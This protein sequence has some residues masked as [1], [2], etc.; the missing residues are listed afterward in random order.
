MP[1]TLDDTKLGTYTLLPADDPVLSA[2]EEL[3]GAFVDPEDPALSASFIE[4][5]S[6]PQGRT[7]QFDLATGRFV[8]YGDRPAELRG[9][10]SLRQWIDFTLVTAAGAHSIFP[11]DYGMDDP[12]SMIGQMYS[13]A[14]ETDWQRQVEKALSIHDRI[15]SVGEFRFE[16][17]EAEEIINWEC[18]VRTVDGQ[19]LTVQAPFEGE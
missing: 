3:D 15:E 11:D 7:W 4:P 19:E 6:A 16:H 9:L 5:K 8:T 1:E 10:E 12:T 2:E 14:L 17:N 18:T 13:P